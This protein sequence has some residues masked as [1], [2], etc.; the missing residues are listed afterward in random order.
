MNV[1]MLA[2]AAAVP[3]P[4][5]L[6][7]H[8]GDQRIELERVTR[9]GKTQR[10]LIRVDPDCRVR[11]HAPVSASDAEVL[12][13]VR[14]RARWIHQ[15]LCV[16]RAQLEHVVPRQYNSGE[17]HLYLGRRYLLKVIEAVDAPAQVRLL[18]GRLE[19]CLPLRSAVAVREL[20]N[21]WYRQRA[22]EV[23]ARRLA[24]LLP[25]TLW[26]S[27]VPPLRIQNMQTQWGSCSPNGCIT[28]NP[29]LVKAPRDCIDY[30]IL[31]E[32]CHLAEHNH[33]ERFYRL[34]QQM[35][36]QWQTVKARLDGM[37]A[38]LLNH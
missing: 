23:F 17:S 26:V 27:S 12:Q 4:T 38:V 19:V 11:V 31:H 16:F 7:L 36:P 1:L 22:R 3:A 35:M 13:A 6:V 9:N 20:L 33:S 25:Q 5:M 37:A 10:V 18:R 14:L 28:L 2:E 24:V 15:Q 21:A 34:L 29:Q 8:Y 32:L 30:V